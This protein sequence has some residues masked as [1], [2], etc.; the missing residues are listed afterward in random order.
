MEAEVNARIRE[1]AEV[2]T[3]LM[4]PEA[5]V[6]AG[7]MALFGEKYG[8]EVRD[9]GM[10]HDPAPAEK[11][12]V[13]SLELC[14]GTHVRR[15]GDIGLFKIIAEGAVSAGVRRVEAVTGD[16]A[17]AYINEMEESL[18]AAAAVLKAQPGELAGRTAA[19]VEERR[20][21]ER[22]VAELRK[23]LATAGGGA[24]IEE[25]AGLRLSLRDLGEV[26]PR[27]WKGLAEAI[28]KGGTADVVALISTAEGKA[29]AL[30]A[31]QAIS[32]RR[33]NASVSQVL[34]RPSSWILKFFSP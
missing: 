25:V 15:T 27:D 7:A 14:G 22:D 16:A 1:N 13:Y 34:D 11:H 33:T 17:L 3:R 18:T 23:K 21:L 32:C 26:P 31:E 30:P 20:K 5:A 24:E 4:T 28:L 29:R 10:G 8:E 9:V 12:G 6:E 19:L 2:I